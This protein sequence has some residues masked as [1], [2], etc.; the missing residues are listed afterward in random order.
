[1]NQESSLSGDP[2]EKCLSWDVLHALKCEGN[3]AGRRSAAAA[4][5]WTFHVHNSCTCSYL[6]FAGKLFLSTGSI[7][8]SDGCEKQDSC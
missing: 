4:N 3:L 7:T 6:N 8:P 2:A 5:H 1:M